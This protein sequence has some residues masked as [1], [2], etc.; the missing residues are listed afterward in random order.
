MQIPSNIGLQSVGAYQR[1]GQ[2]GVPLEPRITT[3]AVTRTPAASA[4][5]E[6]Q[7]CKNRTYVD[8]SNDAS[9]SFKTPTNISPS[10]SYAAV[11]AHENEHVVNEQAKAQKEGGKVV[12]QSVALHYAVCPECGRAYVAGGTTTTVVRYGADKNAA[13]YQRGAFA[14]TGQIVDAR[15]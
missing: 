9:V 11:S 8:G 12:S 14:G 4:A 2:P 13:R 10:N 15:V 1:M 6:C 3:D 5:V 7:T